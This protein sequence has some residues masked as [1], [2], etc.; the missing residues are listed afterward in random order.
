MPTFTCVHACIYK[1]VIC[2]KGTVV[3]VSEDELKLPEHERLTQAASFRR[4]AATETEA[5]A[6]DPAKA[7]T[8]ADLFQKAIALGLTPK[9]KATAA[10]LADMIA[11][12]A[13]PDGA[14]A[15][16]EA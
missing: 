6:P 1:G 8:R 4:H 16:P 11:D 15:Q 5:A 3:R 12:A 7:G 13:S 14:A 10:Q 9:P 2:K